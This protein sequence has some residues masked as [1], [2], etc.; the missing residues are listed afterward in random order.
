[1]RTNTIM[2]VLGGGLLVVGCQTKSGAGTGI[3]AVAGGALGQAV[4]GNVGMIVGAAAGGALGY[5]LG[6]AMEEE[7]RRRMAYSLSANEPVSWQNP[8]TGYQY[9]VEPTDT[10]YIGQRECREYQLRADVGGRP[11]VIR[12]TACRAPD[13]SWEA[14]SG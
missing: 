13:G 4:G 9:M 2:L 12:G 1:M 7:D 5:T 11:D 10:R 6:S 14:M 3:G 8:E